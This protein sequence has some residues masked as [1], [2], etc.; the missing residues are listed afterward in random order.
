[1]SPEWSA[2]ILKNMKKLLEIVEDLVGILFEWTAREE[3]EMLMK[4]L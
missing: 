2:V 1:M 3:E 4:Q